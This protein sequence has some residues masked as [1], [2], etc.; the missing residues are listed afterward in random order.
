ML[1]TCCWRLDWRTVA[2]ASHRDVHATLLS[3][4]SLA[5]EFPLCCQL[6]GLLHSS[7]LRHAAGVWSVCEYP[8]EAA[9]R[10]LHGDRHPAHHGA[11]HEPAPLVWHCT[12]FSSRGCK[13]PDKVSLVADMRALVRLQLTVY[14]SNLVF[15]LKPRDL[16]ARL[17]AL[18]HGIAGSSS[19]PCGVQDIY[20]RV[21]QAVSPVQDP[22]SPARVCHGTGRA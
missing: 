6:V 10:V 8:C 1:L 9:Q 14:L 13:D 11:P 15:F 22:V 18:N 19:S 7:E 16:E 4:R 20:H 12:A 3:H 21:Y 5:A 2:S 17:G